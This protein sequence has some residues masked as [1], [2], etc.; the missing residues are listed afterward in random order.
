MIHAPNIFSPNGS[1]T[2]EFFNIWTTRAVKYVELL[3]V[4]DRWGNLVFQGKDIKA[5]IPGM[6]ITN[7]TKSGWDGTVMRRDSNETNPGQ[8]AVTGV[9][10]WRARVR[11]IDDEVKN[12]AGDLTLVR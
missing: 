12:F 6:L 2:N 11:F 1:G 3:E 4:Y 8:D 7:D 5:P 9:Y 10:A